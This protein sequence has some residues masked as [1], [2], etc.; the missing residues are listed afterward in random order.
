M[1]EKIVQNQIALQ[2]LLQHYPTH[3]KPIE[4]LHDRALNDPDKYLREWAE[5]EV[6]RRK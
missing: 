3:P 4:I 1:S 6:R 5:E 2:L